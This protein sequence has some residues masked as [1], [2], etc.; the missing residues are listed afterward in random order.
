MNSAKLKRSL[1]RLMIAVVGFVAFM[2]LVVLPVGASFLITN[3]RFQ[4]RERGPKTPEAV[5]LSVTNVEF[6]S[7]DG[8]P[9]ASTPRSSTA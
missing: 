7:S 9:L 6:T 4:Y 1:I 2:L 3:S 5:G 8:I